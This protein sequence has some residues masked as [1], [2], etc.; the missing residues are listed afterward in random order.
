[1][2]LMLA[3]VVNNNPYVFDWSLVRFRIRK[4]RIT[5]ARIVLPFECKPKTR[6]SFSKRT[7]SRE[8]VI[9]KFLVWFGWLVW[10][11]HSLLVFVIVECYFNEFMFWV[12]SVSEW[13]SWSLHC[14]NVLKPILLL[15]FLYST[16][17]FEYFL[18]K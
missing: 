13:S 15:W 9:V 11:R 17:G 2:V 1:M 5:T 7:H 10:G 12:F 4:K 6:F 3:I 18:I 14:D 16:H 8:E